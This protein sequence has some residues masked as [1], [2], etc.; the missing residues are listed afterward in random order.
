MA[1]LPRDFTPDLRR[2][3]VWPTMES[4]PWRQPYL[5]DLTYGEMYRLA[6][7]FVH[8]LKVRILEVGCGQGF[9]SLELAR[10]GHDVLGIDVDEKVV[11]TAR[12]VMKSNPHKSKRGTVDCEASVSTTRNSLVRL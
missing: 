9:L 12:R 5:A 2:L 1:E 3:K 4:S 6:N 10:K 11:K 7:A 8:G